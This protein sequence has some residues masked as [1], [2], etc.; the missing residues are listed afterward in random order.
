MTKKTLMMSARKGSH[1]IHITTKCAPIVATAGG[2]IGILSPEIY[3][4]QIYRRLT[5]MLPVTI[6]NKTCHTSIQTKTLFAT[7]RLLR[8]TLNDICFFFQGDCYII[9]Q[10][11]H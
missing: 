5:Q 2:T 3:G 10:T 4:M 11:C 9:V 8:I 6:I 1:D 7:Y